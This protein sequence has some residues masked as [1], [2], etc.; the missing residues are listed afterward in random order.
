M[1]V[2]VCVRE[3]WSIVDIPKNVYTRG[4]LDFAIMPPL[5]SVDFMD[6]SVEVQY[7]K[8]RVYRDSN[9]TVYRERKE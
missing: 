7:E 1:R 2:S 6:E 3:K 4:Y 9:S 8:V 5:K